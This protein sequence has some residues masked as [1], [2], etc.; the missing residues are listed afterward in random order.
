MQGIEEIISSI[1]ITL[2]LA[3]ILGLVRNFTGWLTNALKDGKI[4]QYEWSQLFGTMS[5]YFGY[6]FM[7]T[8]GLPVDQAVIAT[9]G[10]DVAKSE[11]TKWRNGNVS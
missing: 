5:Q 11:V 4:D 8:I 9:F 1:P 2:A 7:F 10:L 6:L 3:V